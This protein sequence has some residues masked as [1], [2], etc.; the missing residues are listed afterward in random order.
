MIMPMAEKP[1]IA[2]VLL[3]GRGLPEAVGRVAP[4]LPTVVPTVTLLVVLAMGVTAT[5]VLTSVEVDSE[6]VEAMVLVLSVVVER[7]SV[8][9]SEEQP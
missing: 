7:V 6:E 2:A 8:T 9:T 5:V 1:A 4:V 3:K